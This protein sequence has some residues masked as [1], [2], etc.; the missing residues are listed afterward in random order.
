MRATLSSFPGHMTTW[1]GNED[2]SIWSSSNDQLDCWN[3]L[4]N[5]FHSCLSRPPHLQVFFFYLSSLMGDRFLK[6]KVLQVSL[7]ISH[8]LLVNPPPRWPSTPSTL[9][10]VERWTSPWEYPDWE[11]SWWQLALTSK[12]QRWMS[13]SCP[14]LGPGRRGRSL[15]NSSPESVSHRWIFWMLVFWNVFLPIYLFSDTYV[16]YRCWK[17]WRFGSL[18]VER[19]KVT[20]IVSTESKWPF[21]PSSTI[22]WA[23]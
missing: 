8:S 19:A 16:I 10:D 13:P 17:R 12:H 14:T 4:V 2:C 1:L 5:C 15:R 22:L 6:M 9:P 7:Y 23:Q 21:Y 20:D 11:R 18:C 3:I